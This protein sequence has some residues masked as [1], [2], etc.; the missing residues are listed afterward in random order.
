MALSSEGR[1]LSSKT[2][3]TDLTTCEYTSAEH[4]APSPELDDRA[5]RQM[6]AGRV[7]RGIRHRQNQTPECSSMLHTLFNAPEG[8]SRLIL[9]PAPQFGIKH[10]HGVRCVH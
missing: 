10:C 4:L 6:A 8:L 3:Y 9:P 1:C 7:T 5:L 2:W